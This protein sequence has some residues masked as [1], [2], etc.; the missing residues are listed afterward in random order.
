M[1][2]DVAEVEPGRLRGV[3][4]I[5]SLRPVVE[6]TDLAFTVGTI[7]RIRPEIR[8]AGQPATW[9]LIHFEADDTVADRLAT[10]LAD[11]LEAGPW[12]V[13]FHTATTT[14]V[15]FSGRIFSY[16][17]DE[18][19]GRRDSAIAHARSVGV[20]EPQLDWNSDFTG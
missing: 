13:D 12:Y 6:L 5:E 9:T 3:L 1:L 10:A 15:I 17:R 19:G 14:Y 4:I 16:H 11:A 2:V 7:S 18:S 8:S 20:P